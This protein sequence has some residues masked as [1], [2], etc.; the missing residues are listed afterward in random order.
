MTAG[1]PL[2]KSVLIL[3]AKSVLIPL[4]LSAS[5]SA[6]DGAIQKKIDGSGTTTLII[7]NDE[8]EDVMKIV[9]SLEESKITNETN[10]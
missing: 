1:L 6:A 2:I 5:M 4:R 8:I 10:Y 9:E 3:L 7:S